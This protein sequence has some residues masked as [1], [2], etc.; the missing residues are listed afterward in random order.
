V[1]TYWQPTVFY[2]TLIVFFGLLLWFHLGSLLNGYSAHEAETLQA[3]QSLRHILDNPVNAPFTV[4]AYLF[5]L[6]PLGDHGAL[7]VRATATLYG[8]IV[9]TTFYWLVRYWHGERSAILGTT[10][11]GCSAWFLHVSRLGTPEALLFI[12]LALL[13]STAWLRKTDS[14]LVLL[15][16]FGLTAALLYIPGMIWLLVAAAI[17]QAKTIL[18]LF[19]EHFSLMI[20][21]SLALLA[22]ATPLVWAIY[23][24]PETA[25]VITGLPAQGWPQP[26]ESLERLAGIV[27]NLLVRGP[28]DA[29][30]WLGRL[31]ILDAFALAMLAL[32][33]YLYMR[34]WRLVRTKMVFVSLS[35]GTLL[36]ALGGAVTIS[37]LMPFIYVLVAAGVGVMLDRWQTVFPRNVIAQSVSLGLISLAVIAASWYGLRHYF[38]AWPNASATKTI[39][40]V[41]P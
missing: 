5:S 8:L 34:H 10:L 11:F 36:I 26:I 24:Q 28:L 21:G 40:V 7:A 4:V 14:R 37:I 32:G 20:L 18:R 12:P 39:F 29:E 38:V 16:G 22:L 2:G 15:A 41:K 31:P 6:T 33:F 27:S 35:V 13:A 30:R 19:K 3:S 23:Q 9:L 17:W 1:A 25:K